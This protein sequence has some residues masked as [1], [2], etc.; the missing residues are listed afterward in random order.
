MEDFSTAFILLVLLATG[1]GVL[2]SWLLLQRK[3][4]GER[5]REQNLRLELERDNHYLQQRKSELENDLAEWKQS[6]DKGQVE[7][8]QKEGEMSR[9][10]TEKEGLEKRLR[11]QK[12]DLEQIQQKLNLE[13]RNLANQILDE[14]S[15]KFTDQNK[16]NLDQILTPLRERIQ[17]FQQKVEKANL[18][19]TR[20]SAALGEQLKHLR[21]LNKQVT[22]EAKSL[23]QALRGDSKSQGNWGEM[24]L[25]SILELAGL[26]RDIHYER[27]K[28][29][30]SEEQQNQRLDFIIN[31]PDGKHLILDSKVSLRAY[32]RY[33]E[34]EEEK[35]KQRFIKEHL[36]NIY[37]H[38]KL[39]GNKDYQNLYGIN[40]PDYVLMFVANEPALNLALR[41]DH[42]LYEKALRSNIVLVSTTTLLATLRT[43]SY[44]WKQDRQNKNAEEIAK[45]AGALY[46]KFVNF[47]EDLVK[48]GRQM[49][50]AQT[51]Y[52]ESM[53]KLTEGRGNLVRRTEELRKLG[54]QSTK[55]QNPKMLDKAD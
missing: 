11:E 38:I 47:T 48:L 12:E 49:D 7:L 31:L 17:E 55:E 3:M 37:T 25:E 50:T 16:Q 14:K 28:T 18:E 22:E 9:L 29:I 5:L 19:D 32:S 40:T 24:Q 42:D 35:E 36:N 41:E 34:S 46:D 26:E 23:T 44:I 39:L 10:T 6:Y 4:A 43:I 51:T 30:R 21:D 27:E 13:F 2:I 52:R 54:A 45:Q 1:L 15:K 20:R 8:R 33:Y 53:K